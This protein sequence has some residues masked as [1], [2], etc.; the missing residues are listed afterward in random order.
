[1]SHIASEKF[2]TEKTLSI[3]K[4]ASENFTILAEGVGTG[5][6]ESLDT[7]NH[8][9]GFDLS[10]GYKQFAEAANLQ[11]QNTQ[12]YKNIAKEK[13]QNVDFSL[14]HLAELLAS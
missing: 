11:S 4:L 7:V 13:I 2:Y 9:V 3:E 12:I 1:M 14:D 5:S 8:F 10:E 6:K